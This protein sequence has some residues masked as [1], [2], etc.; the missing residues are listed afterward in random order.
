MTFAQWMKDTAAFGR[1]R[2]KELQA[3]DQA[4]KKYELAAEN[5]AGSVLN[6]RRALGGALEA[7]KQAQKAKGQDWRTSVRNSKK[8]V[9]LLDAELGTVI[10]GKGGLNSRGEL[11][12]DPAE[13][14]AR[15]E[16]ARAIKD[17]TKTMFLGQKLTVKTTKALSDL[18][19]VR[20]SLA[21]FKKKVGEI[22]SPAQAASPGLSQQV[23]SMVTSVLGG[24]AGAEVA[25]VLGTGFIG[26]I[27]TSATPFVGAIKS[28]VSAISK[29]GS[30]AAGLWKRHK[31][32]GADGSFAAGDPQAAFEAIV[33]IQTREVHAYATEASIHTLAAGAKAA[34]TAADF[35]AVSGAVLGAAET[36]A[37][38][39][40]KL[41]LWARDCSEIEEANGL[42][43]QGVFDFTLF[44][45][46]PLLG[47][48]LIASSDTSAIVNMAVGDY[49][50]A[51]WK[52]EVEVM[53]KNAQPVFDKARTVIHDSRFEIVGLSGMK[54]SVVDRTKKTGQWY[55]K[56]GTK[57]LGGIPTGKLDGLIQDVENTINRMGDAKAAAA[58]SSS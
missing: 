50:R 10:V 2:S 40:Q 43:L 45:S 34:F 7:W 23:Q 6:E 58:P 3:V 17:N 39:M 29:W 8:T 12:I 44:K 37:V 1:S 5:S 56:H 42:I 41:Y 13:L 25:H 48:Y 38:M 21:E 11:V 18:S 22:R 31:L 35:G 30:A 33:R 26:E 19:S 4:F 15:Q 54:G 46:C 28:G 52:F 51:G 36:L 20:S 16:I 57:V 14:K 27:V 53:V 32:N 55:T 49:G 24:S 47:C 9:E